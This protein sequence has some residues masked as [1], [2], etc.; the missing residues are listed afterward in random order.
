[1][2]VPGFGDLGQER[3]D[4][5][6]L[7]DADDVCGLWKVKKSWLYD[8]VEAG[9]IPVIRFGRQLWFRRSDIAAYIDRLAR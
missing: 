2:P 9:D 3:P 6:S 4:P 8:A 7:L 5:L 1:M